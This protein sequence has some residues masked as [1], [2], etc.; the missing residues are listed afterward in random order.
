VVQQATVR[1][2]PLQRRIECTDRQVPI[3]DRADRPADHEPREQIQNHREIELAAA[4]D[5]ELRRVADPTP[6]GG[7]GM[8]LLV[9]EVGRHR[10][11]AIAHRGRL[12]TLARPRLQA[13]FLHQAHD[14]L[15]ADADAILD[16]ILPH[17]RTAVSLAA[18]FERGAYPHPQL[19]ILQRVR[20]LRAFAQAWLNKV[21][22]QLN[23]RPRR[24]LAFRTPA[25]ALH[26]ALR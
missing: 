4:A 12:E 15:A 7:R 26:A 10:L 17:S 8:K 2:A 5:H 11:V 14:S 22:R 19:T 24:T 23:E 9:Q 3:I 21:A 18:G 6:I 13:V 16:E 25:D 1:A 20:R